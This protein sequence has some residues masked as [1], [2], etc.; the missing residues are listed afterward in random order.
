MKANIGSLLWYSAS[1]G[2][3][4]SF[5]YPFLVRVNLNLLVLLFLA[6]VVDKPLQ[7]ALSPFFKVIWGKKHRI[8]K[9]NRTLGKCIVLFMCCTN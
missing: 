9:V 4:F 7:L 6:K 3:Q 8:S 1:L 5:S 2:F